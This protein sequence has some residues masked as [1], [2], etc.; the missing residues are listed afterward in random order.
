MG[1]LFLGSQDAVEGRFRSDI[2]ARIGQPGNDLPWRKVPVFWGIGY[3]QN[4]LSFGQRQLMGGC[5]RTVAPIIPTVQG[6]PALDG[7]AR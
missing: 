2:L 1:Q 6:S 7:A 3:G 4:L 5:A